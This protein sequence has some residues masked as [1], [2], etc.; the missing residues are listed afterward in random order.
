MHPELSAAAR[1]GVFTS[2]EA[3]RAGYDVEDIRSELRSRRWSRLRKGVYIAT[4]ELAT[5]TDRDRH[6]IDC[7]AVLLGL[8]DRP[9]L[10]HASAARLHELIVPRSASDEVRLTTTGQWRRGRRYRVAQAALV[11]GETTPWLEFAA[12]SVARTLVDCAREWSVTDAV[13]AMDS[14]INERKVTRAELLEAVLGGRHR[15]G[16]AK[17]ARALGLADGRAESALETR[18]RLAILAAGL[19]RPE[20][21]VEIHDDGGRFLGRVDAWYEDAAVAIEFDGLV[22]Y[23]D[24]RYASSAGQVLWL[25]K[26]REDAMRARGIRFVRIGNADLGPPWTET[27]GQIG[28]LLAAPF[29]GLRRFRAVRTDEPDG[30]S[31][32][33]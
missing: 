24:P 31:D 13:V 19:P 2:Q 23:T 15:V 4:D 14:A 18:G 1:L 20:L 27:A 3:L 8:A 22:K 26:R 6:L 12:T 5:A 16:I 25:E 33:A 29:I 10:S 9:V 28:A 30:A 32:V 17:A 21:Q 11:A 7:V